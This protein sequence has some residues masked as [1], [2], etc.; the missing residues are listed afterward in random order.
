MSKKYIWLTAFAFLLTLG[1]PVFADTNDNNQSKPCLCR[2][3]KKQFSKL[4]LTQEQKAKIKAIKTQARSITK[5]NY[6]QLKVIKQQINA[7]IM[8]E[9]IDE[10]KLD[11]LISQRN[12]ITGAMLKN[13]IMMKNQ[14]Y[15]VLTN[16]QK[17]QYKNMKQSHT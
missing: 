2:D 7:L 3:F 15:N 14:I 13:R 8:S 17:L 10:A 12:K 16:E 4:N 6:K 5:A 11:N 1:Q 9:K